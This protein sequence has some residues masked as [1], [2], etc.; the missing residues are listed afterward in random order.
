MVD[1]V[2][3]PP[4]ESAHPNKGLPE[5]AAEPG[6]FKSLHMS[7]RRRRILIAYQPKRGTHLLSWQFCQC[8]WNGGP[9]KKEEL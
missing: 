9:P 3:E 8:N 4:I 7:R 5:S 6:I 1:S 2:Y